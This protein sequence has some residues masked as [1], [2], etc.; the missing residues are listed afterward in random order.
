VDDVYL[1]RA[2][3]KGNPRVTDETAPVLAR[4]TFQ[5]HFGRVGA[6][7]FGDLQEEN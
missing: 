5:P 4:V 1:F 6:N 3:A 2:V 7:P